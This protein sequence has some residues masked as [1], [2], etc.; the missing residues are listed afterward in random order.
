MMWWIHQ[1][2]DSVQKALRTASVLFLQDTESIALLVIVTY[3]LK[4]GHWQLETIIRNKILIVQLL[5]KSIIDLELI[6]QKC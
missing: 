3:P 6:T 1:Y 5:E 4:L 2:R